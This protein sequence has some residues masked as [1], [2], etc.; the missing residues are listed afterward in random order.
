MDCKLARRRENKKMIKKELL[1]AL[2]NLDAETIINFVDN[3]MKEVYKKTYS[4][5][6]FGWTYSIILDSNGELWSTLLSP[7]SR[8]MEVFKGDSIILGSIN[9]ESEIESE[10]VNLDVINNLT[11]EEREKFIEE[12]KTCNR[13]FYNIT[14]KTS[15]LVRIPFGSKPNMLES[16]YNKFVEEGFLVWDWTID[17]EDW[18][19]STD[20][21]LSNILY[22]ARDKKEIVILLHENER[23]V[24]CLNDII[25]ILK[26]RGYD[27]R[28]ITDDIKP[29]N[30]W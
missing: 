1:N 29:K 24:S 9:S 11:E 5:P 19:S 12:F 30:F 16:I 22:Y 25:T 4:N 6:V 21:I 28:P 23:T 15:R 10:L 14:G 26:K 13:T 17:T 20:Q 18:K 3:E 27:I 7:G 8:P 2:K